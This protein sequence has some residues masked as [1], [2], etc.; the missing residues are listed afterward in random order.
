MGS[1]KTEVSKDFK[2]QG[3]K[4]TTKDEFPILEECLATWLKQ[5]RSEN[6]PLGGLILKEKAKAFAKKLNISNFMA[7]ER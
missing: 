3:R 7:T 5:Y 6:V 1:K 2:I 4:R